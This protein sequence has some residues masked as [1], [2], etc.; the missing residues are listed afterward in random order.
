MLEWLLKTFG[1][2]IIESVIRSLADAFRIRRL[3]HERDDAIAGRAV[4]EQR[5][6]NAE[7]ENQF[8]KDMQDAQTSAP[9]TRRDLADRL[10]R[11]SVSEGE[12]KS[13]TTN[14]FAQLLPFMARRD[15]GTKG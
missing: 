3:D 9:S 6:A 14:H 7:A 15:Q 4:A 12:A 13:G 8:R 10:R 2:T 5:V 11:E 1:G